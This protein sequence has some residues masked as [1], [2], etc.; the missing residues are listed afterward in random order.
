MPLKRA[1]NDEICPIG[2][3]SLKTIEEDPLEIC[4]DCDFGN[5]GIVGDYDLD[6]ICECPPDMTRKEFKKIKDL[7][8]KSNSSPSREEFWKFVQENYKPQQR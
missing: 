8:Q 2:C 4:L 7:Y 5:T 1:N 3:F 6:K